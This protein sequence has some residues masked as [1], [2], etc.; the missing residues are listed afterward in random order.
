MKL[1]E[2]PESVQVIIAQC[3]QTI[4]AEKVYWDSKETRTE[5]AKKL[6]ISVR[7]AFEEAFK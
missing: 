5:D 2:L 6:A 1:V 7:E 3:I 4:I